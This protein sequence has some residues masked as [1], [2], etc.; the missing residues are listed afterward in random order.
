MRVSRSL[1]FLLA[2]APAVCRCG[3][4]PPAQFGAAPAPAP[5]AGP[6]PG[7]DTLVY[8]SPNARIAA[9]PVAMPPNRGLFG[10][11]EAA[12]APP[13]VRV[14][15]PHY[16]MPMAAAAY[17]PAEPN[18]VYTLDSGDRL[19]VVVFGQDGLS[20]SYLVGARGSARFGRP[21]CPPTTSPAASPKSCAKVLCASRTSR[22]KSRLTGRFSSSA[23]SHS[24]ANI[25]MWPT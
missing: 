11:P 23:K 22:S 1:L 21:P 14:A 7:I 10:A 5:V 4:L 12:I 18:R 9:A 16:V 3:Q 2:F 24:L 13:A 17:A 15:G 20:T 6:A 25:P 8:G 19:R